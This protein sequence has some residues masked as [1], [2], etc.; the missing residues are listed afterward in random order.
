[1]RC[2]FVV[3]PYDCVIAI[4]RK[5]SQCIEGC[6][7][8]AGFKSTSDGE[9]RLVS[10]RLGGWDRKL[11]KKKAR[12]SR[13]RGIEVSGSTYLSAGESKLENRGAKMEASGP[14]SGSSVVVAVIAV[15]GAVSGS[16]HSVPSSPL[17]V[18]S[19]PESGEAGPL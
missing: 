7:V 9:E 1:M 10:F 18:D 3:C 12:L 11:A 17:S 4:V 16:P 19:S 13:E 8:G 15:V 6:G 5:L 14:A 2:G